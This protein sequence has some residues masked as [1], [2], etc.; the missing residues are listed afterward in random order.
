MALMTKQLEEKIVDV[1]AQNK[2]CSFA[3]VEGN[4]PHVRYMALFHEGL[5]VYLATNRQTHK[6]E[7]L[8]SNPNVHILLGYN[9]SWSSEFLQIEG[10]GRVAKDEGLRSKVWRDD[11]SMWFDGPD[12]PNYVIL[13]IIPARI[14]YSG[15]GKG[16][17]PEVWKKS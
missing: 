14:E 16:A 9:G 2:V 3:T 6:V 15:G 5:T 17:Q 7:E 12:D 13:E 8:E 4:K 11:F 1:L 10:T